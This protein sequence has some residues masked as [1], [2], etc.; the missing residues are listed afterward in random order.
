MHPLQL[1]YHRLFSR[2]IFIL[3][4]NQ[5]KV[6]LLRG[7]VPP[8]FVRELREIIKGQGVRTGFVLASKKGDRRMLKISKEIP[9]SIHQRI[10]NVWGYY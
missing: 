4:I 1:I 3:A 2:P 7:E 6:R 9:A 5:G 8:G 10:R